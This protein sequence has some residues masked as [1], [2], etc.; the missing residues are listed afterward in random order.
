MKNWKKYLK[1][2]YQHENHAAPVSR[3]DFLARGLMASLGAVM[4]PSIE[5][6]LSRRLLYGQELNCPTYASSP[7]PM[8]P[9]LQLDHAGGAA[10]GGDFICGAQGGQLDLL[11]ASG[12]STDYENFGYPS[13]LHPSNLTP[14]TTFGVAFHANSPFLMGLKAA[15]PSQYWNSVDGGIVASATDSDTQANPL[16]MLQ[17]VP[18]VDRY[19][20]VVPAVGTTLKGSGGNNTLAPDPIG[21]YS[22]LS[23]PS[24]VSNATEALELTGYIDLITSFGEPIAQRVLQA[25]GKLNSSQLSSF[26]NMNI[27]DQLKELQECGYLRATDLAFSVPPEELFNANEAE[28]LDSFGAGF[29]ASSHTRAL[30]PISYLLSKGYVGGGCVSVGGFDNHVGNSKDPNAIRYRAGFSVGLA[31]KYFASKEMPLFIAGLTDGY[32]G[33]KRVGGILQVDNTEASG[34]VNTLDYQPGGLGTAS[35][36][37]DSN[38][39]GCQ[40]FLAYVP[41]KSR[42][43]LIENS[44]RQIGAFSNKGVVLNYLQTANAP[45]K[46]AQAIFYQYL[47]L[48]GLESK[49]NLVLGSNH[50]LNA[51]EYKVLKK[52]W[53][54]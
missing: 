20:T 10:F 25:I 3:R 23:R 37:G 44:G 54:V 1:P 31:I 39:V 24:K 26:K 30:A 22:A 16:G 21:G 7:S 18:L 51:P 34:P 6:I 38:L 12:N 47:L 48:Q 35:R 5:S 43:D 11:T 40:W 15:L 46:A 19:G 27:S 45:G 28:L 42:G 8:I 4:A 2:E 49:M 36:P 53:N 9:F 29:N 17:Y 13:D 52:A 32:M 50:F 33:V 41:G 14:D